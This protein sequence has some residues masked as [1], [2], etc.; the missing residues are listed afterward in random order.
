[1]KTNFSLK[2]T[3]FF[4]VLDGSSTVIAGVATETPESSTLN[5]VHVLLRKNSTQARGLS[6]PKRGDGYLQKSASNETSLLNGFCH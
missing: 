6:D 4:T 5:F 3:A 2:I 1:M